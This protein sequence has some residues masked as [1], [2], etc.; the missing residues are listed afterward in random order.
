MYFFPPEVTSVQ[1][2]FS[3]V[4]FSAN[5]FYEMLLYVNGRSLHLEVTLR[6]QRG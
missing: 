3:F 4:L 6:Q 1:S 2:S 5:P